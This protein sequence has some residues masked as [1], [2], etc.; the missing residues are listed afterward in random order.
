MF[1]IT[2]S[3]GFFL[4]LNIEQ[5]GNNGW[6]IITQTTKTFRFLVAL[7]GKERIFPIGFGYREY[8]VC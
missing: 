7:D 4:H 6:G 1:G 5:Y 8:G 3:F 2:V